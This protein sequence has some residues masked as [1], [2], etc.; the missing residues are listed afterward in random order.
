MPDFQNFHSG[1]I[2]PR[3]SHGVVRTCKNHPYLRWDGKNIF[4]RS[5][6]FSGGVINGKS[7]GTSFYSTS[8]FLERMGLARFQ[9]GASII[10]EHFEHGRILECICSGRDLRLLTA[11]EMPEGYKNSILTFF[12]GMSNSFVG[13]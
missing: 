3:F 11:D 12:Q 1:D 10:Q 13:V 7:Y 6:F 2:D 5:I 4:D 8:G 9:E